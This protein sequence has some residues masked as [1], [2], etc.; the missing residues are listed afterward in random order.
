MEY[1]DV[2]N[3]QSPQFDIPVVKLLNKG[4]VFVSING[5][6]DREIEHLNSFLSDRY[7]VVNLNYMQ[8]L[9]SLHLGRR[10]SRFYYRPNFVS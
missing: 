5:V 6:A 9:Y 4:T 1:L 2:V 10:S 3:S 8:Y 7:H